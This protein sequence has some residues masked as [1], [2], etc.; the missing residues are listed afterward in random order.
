MAFYEVHCK[1]S[2]L[3]RVLANIGLPVDLV[4][5]DIEGVEYKVFSSSRRVQEVPWII[6]ELKGETGQIERFVHMFPHHCAEVVWVSRKM[7]VVY[8]WCRP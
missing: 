6:G 2:A 8:L 7:A 1:V 4:K 3:D 5:F